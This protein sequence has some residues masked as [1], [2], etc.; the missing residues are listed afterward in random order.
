M[1]KLVVLVGLPGSGK[2]AFQKRH[3]EWAVV[4]KDAIRRGVFHCN[5]A[6]EYEQV[7]DR[8]FASTLVEVI[9]SDAETV[10]VDDLNHTRA[11]R[12]E[13]I[14]LA[15][16]TTREAVAYVM[17]TKPLD[18]LFARTRDSLEQLSA[19]NAYIRVTDLSRLRFE[20]LARS[21]DPV[22]AREGFTRVAK[23]TALPNEDDPMD[24][25]GTPQVARRRRRIEKRQP[26]PLFVP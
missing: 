4:S 21:Y 26:L 7:V 19:S 24:S 20:E 5:Y 18:A 23:E 13:L 14:E 10:C 2:T 22:D 1:K 3:P 16:L 8:I 6:P 12:A 15:Q 11:A 25:S 9:A 17:P